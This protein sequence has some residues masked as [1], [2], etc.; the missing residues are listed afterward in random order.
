MLG[1]IA[2]SSCRFEKIPVARFLFKILHSPR[3][4]E[5]LQLFLWKFFTHRPNLTQQPGYDRVGFSHLFPACL[6]HVCKS[7][8]CSHPCDLTTP[9]PCECRSDF[10]TGGWQTNASTCDK[11]RAYRFSNPPRH[12]SPLLA[13]YFRQCD[14]A[15]FSG[16]RLRSPK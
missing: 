10:P 3:S 15:A 1:V 16:V 5:R 8:L 4:P 9:A 12:V 6:E 14:A 13:T 2:R 7:S 11:W